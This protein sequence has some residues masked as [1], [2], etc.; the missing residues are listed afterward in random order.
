VAP[1]GRLPFGC[2]SLEHP[3]ADQKAHSAF[4]SRNDSTSRREG[5]P[6]CPPA[7]IAFKAAAAAAGGV[8][9]R[10]AKCRLVARRMRIFGRNIP[11]TL[12]S[13]SGEAIQDEK[14]AFIISKSACVGSERTHASSGNQRC[15]R[16]PSRVALT[17]HDTRFGVRSRKLIQKEKIVNSDSAQTQHIE[18]VLH[19]LT[20]ASVRGPRGRGS[21][22]RRRVEQVSRDE[23]PPQ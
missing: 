10:H 13:H 1:G 22:M 23:I 14:G 7:R 16:Q 11:G 9:D 17:P 5:M 2:H 4:D 21:S 19:R 12:D 15:T 18:A 3:N 8:H 6:F 20:C